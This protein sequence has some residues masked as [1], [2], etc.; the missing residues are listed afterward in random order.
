MDT[1][2]P[3]THSALL[4]L[5]NNSYAPLP[6]VSELPDEWK[7]SETES[8]SEE[9]VEAAQPD[10]GEDDE[11]QPPSDEP[12]HKQKQ[13]KQGKLNFLSDGELQ[14]RVAHRRLVAPRGFGRD[15]DEMFP[16]WKSTRKP[17]KV[18]GA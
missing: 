3:V 1:V 10:P 14:R 15:D 6:P 9:E 16:L 4:L 18:R 2:T 5:W 12:Q 13:G 11:P 17:T 7:L 8:S